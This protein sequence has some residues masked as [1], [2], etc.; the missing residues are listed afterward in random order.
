MEQ[1]EGHAK[2][3]LEFD[4]RETDALPKNGAHCT[5]RFLND[6]KG[7][8]FHSPDCPASD[9]AE[10]KEQLEK[11]WQEIQGLRDAKKSPA[12]RGRW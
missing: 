5:Y 6:G 11:V 3:V 9:L 8:I 2:R 7:V 1:T 12:I 10:A 4:L